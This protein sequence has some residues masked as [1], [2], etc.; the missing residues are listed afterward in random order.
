MSVLELSCQSGVPHTQWVPRYPFDK[1]LTSNYV[2]HTVLGLEFQE[3]TR[4]TQFFLPYILSGETR[5]KK[6]NRTL[7]FTVGGTEMFVVE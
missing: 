4:Q 6:P 3:R 1:R 7:D 5:Q 2:P